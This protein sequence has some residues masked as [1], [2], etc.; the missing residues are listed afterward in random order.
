MGEDLEVNSRGN[1][2]IPYG[3][4]VGACAGSAPPVSMCVHTILASRPSV[5]SAWPMWLTAIAW[6]GG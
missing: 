1:A 3:S 4:N 2:K 5:L 6:H